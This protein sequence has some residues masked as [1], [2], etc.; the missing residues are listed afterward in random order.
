MRTGLGTQQDAQEYCPPSERMS[1]GQSDGGNGLSAGT[2]W[3]SL[4]NCWALTLETESE[5]AL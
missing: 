3:P 5:K 4:D 1:H 2:L